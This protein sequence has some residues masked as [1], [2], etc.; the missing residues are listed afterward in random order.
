M[1]LADH[2]SEEKAPDYGEIE[3]FID[4]FLNVVC[5]A[6]RRRILAYLSASSEQESHLVERSVGEIAQHLNL[7]PSTTSEH[8]KQLLQMHLLFTRREGKKSYYR[9]RNQALVQVFHDLIVSLEAHYHRN[10]L[11]PPLS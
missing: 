7:A 5:D 4:H 3:H 2:G 8:L 6:S 9:L 1:D 11:P 10:F